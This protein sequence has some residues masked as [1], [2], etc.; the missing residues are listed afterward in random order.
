MCNAEALFLYNNVYPSSH[1]ERISISRTSTVIRIKF[2]GTNTKITVLDI[3]TEGHPD[4]DYGTKTN[5]HEDT[6]KVCGDDISR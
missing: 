4:R 6:A 1:V 2:S 3:S 5:I